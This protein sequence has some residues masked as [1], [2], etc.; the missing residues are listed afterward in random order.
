MIPEALEI[1]IEILDAEGSFLLRACRVTHEGFF[2]RTDTPRL[3]GQLVRLRVPTEDDP[4]VLRLLAVVLESVS[5]QDALNSGGCPGMGLKLYGLSSYSRTRWHRW[6]TWLSDHL[7]KLNVQPE[8]SGALPVEASFTIFDHLFDPS[9]DATRRSD[10][11][12]Q[13]S[14]QARLRHDELEEEIDTINVSVGGV[15]LKSTQALDL[16][17]VLPLVLYHP[18]DGGHFE[19]NVEVVRIARSAP[20]LS[21][22]GVQFQAKDTFDNQRLRRF[23]LS[24]IPPEERES[25]PSYIPEHDPLIESL[26]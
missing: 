1:P 2:V 17:Q 9:C 24:G 5:K 3:Q 8:G 19:V 12:Y 20:D 21:H 14:W 6:L 11:R 7:R 23:I 16:G 18:E 13:V 26:G 15:L 22:Y 4:P 25:S 10:I